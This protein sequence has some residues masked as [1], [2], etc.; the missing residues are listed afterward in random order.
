MKKGT[1]LTVGL[2]LAFASSA[3]MAQEPPFGGAA[4]VA[5][6]NHLWEHLVKEKL[7]GKNS[8]HPMPYKTPPP[9][10]SFVE[11]MDGRIT[12]NGHTGVIIVKSNLGERD[13]T[14]IE[15]VINNP[16]K[17]LGSVTVMFQREKGYDSDNLDWFWAKYSPTGK[18]LN[19]PKGMALSGRV[20]KGGQKGCIPCHSNAPGGDM[21]YI[22]DRYAR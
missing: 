22:H 9:H 7:V 10:G 5:Y 16:Q 15:D 1:L 4:D 8:F 17:Y 18:L 3:A 20:A 13:K 2:I 21:V 12:I 14:K 11:T 6:G 19:N